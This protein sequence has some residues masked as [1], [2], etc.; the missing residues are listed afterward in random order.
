M[1]IRTSYVTNS[2]SS[3]FILA[4]KD[5]Y[6]INRFIEDCYSY[7]Y[8]DFLKLIENLAC[9][10][11][12]FS[13]DTKNPLSI[14]PLIDRLK[15]KGLGLLA[16]REMQELYEKDYY[17]KPYESVC[18]KINDLNEQYVDLDNLDFDEI[19]EEDVYTISIINNK[20]HRNKEKALEDLRWQYAARYINELLDTKFKR[21]N[22]ETFDEFMNARDE[23]K[24]TKE[25][26]DSVEDYLKDTDFPEKKEQIEK[27]D[28][29]VSG[30]IWDTSGGLLEWS[31]R[32]GFIE[33]NFYKNCINCFNVG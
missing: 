31:I 2:S 4:F 16:Y 18:V 30:M 6:D 13:N 24:K 28:L 33:D 11:I 12:D 21:D 27:S 17:L 20:E 9:D 5:E 3:S 10:F 1:K 23:Y 14:R 32:N 25:Y 22:Y 29:I 19:E 7:C 15:G 8:D 26:I